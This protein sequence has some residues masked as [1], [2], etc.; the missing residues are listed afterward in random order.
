MTLTISK[1]SLTKKRW[2]IIMPTV[3]IIYSLG[4]LDRVNFGFAAAGGMINELNLTPNKYSLIGSLFF[5]GYFFFQVP[6]T[7]YAERH[8]VKKVLIA[9]LILWGICSSLTGVISNVYSL[10]I[11]RFT[12]GTIESVMQPCIIIYL[13][14]WFVESER[15]RANTYF[16]LGNPVTILWMSILSGYLIHMYNW[17]IMFIA[18]GIPSVVWAI[19]CWFLMKDNPSEVTWMNEE[20]KQVLGDILEEEN[21]KIINIKNYM[22]AFHHP[23]ILL[24]CLQYFCWSI[25]IYG[26]ILWLPSI[27]KQASLTG[28]IAVGWLSTAPYAGAIVAMIIISYLSDKR[29]ER[30]L[31]IW[32]SLFVGMI[33]FICS[34]FIGANNFWLSYILLI[35][36]GSAMYAPYG[37]FFAII[38]TIVP[39]NVLGGCLALVNSM[40]AL[41]SFVGAYFVGLLN[42]ITGSPNSSYIFMAT[43]LFLSVVVTIYANKL[44]FSK[45][46]KLD[47]N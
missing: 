10:F 16:I 47:H 45:S 27:I 37:P 2:F 33:S 31:Y 30:Y 7:I 46:I 3:F 38:P 9:S 18:E 1:Q 36:A 13:T 20:E 43:S 22:E 15:G 12:L 41:G 4:F 19:I 42:G 24:L 28:I 32:V 35:I 44:K 11:I 29:G 6:G 14:R 34:Y 39:R 21:K 8:S 17:R 5:L 23:K 26:F 25:G 40:G